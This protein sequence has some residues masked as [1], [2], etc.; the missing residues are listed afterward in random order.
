M[1]DPAKAAEL[2]ADRERD[3]AVQEAIVERFR[4]LLDEEEREPIDRQRRLTDLLDALDRNGVE[5]P[6]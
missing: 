3:I 6:R 5:L 4:D 1:I 2:L